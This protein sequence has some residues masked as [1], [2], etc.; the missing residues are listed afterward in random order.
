MPRAR[1]GNVKQ[2]ALFL[3]VKAALRLLF[4]HQFRG[5]FEHAG[6]FSRRKTALHEAQDVDVIE[7]QALGRVHGHELHR[8]A[9]FL[10][11]VDRSAGLIEIIQVLDKFLQALRFALGLPLAHEL[12]EAVEIFAVFAG[13]GRADFQS[14]GQLVE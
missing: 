3:D 14:L 6:F 4:L 1:H 12:R 9:G 5:E 13:S 8:V 10:L 11:E 7:F 2:A